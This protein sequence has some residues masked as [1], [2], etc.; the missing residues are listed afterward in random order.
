[1]RAS[2]YRPVDAET[3]N[4]VMWNFFNLFFTEFAVMQRTFQFYVDTITT[5]LLE[6]EYA[7]ILKL[8][9]ASAHFLI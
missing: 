3:R 9:D 5:G 8:G 7:I 2:G 6:P 4:F 1:M